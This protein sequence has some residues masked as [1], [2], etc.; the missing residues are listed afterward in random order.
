MAEFTPSKKTAQDF[1]NGVEYVDGIGDIEGDAVQA[2][3]INS[4]IEGLLYTQGLAVNQPDVSEANQVGTVNASIIMASD[5]TARL[6]FKN[7]KGEQGVGISTIVENGTDANGG[8]IYKI[9]LDDGRTYNLVAPKGAKG[10]TGN[11]IASTDISYASNASGTTAPTTGWQST[12]PTITQGGYLWTKTVV[13][14]TDNSSATSYT[15]AYQGLDGLGAVISVNGQTGAVVLTANDINPF[16]ACS[17][18]S[19]TAAKVVAK[20]GFTLFVGARITVSFTNANTV[21]SPTLNANGT[22]AK[23]I[24]ADDDTTYVK[25]LAGAV[26]DFVYDGINWVC[27]AGYQLAG[28]RVGALYSSHNSTSPAT[29]YGGSWTQISGRSIVAYDATEANPLYKGSYNPATQYYQNQ[30]VSHNTKYWACKQDAKG[31][32]PSTTNSAYWAEYVAGYEGGSADAVVVKHNHSLT[33]GV[34]ANGSNNTSSGDITRI[35]GSTSAN[36]RYPSGLIAEEGE[37]GTGKNM[38]PYRAEYMWYRTA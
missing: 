14:F 30:I 24:K 38:P 32:T 36:A 9:T 28:K 22:G 25:W 23:A 13:T 6:K 15:V 2:E 3:S 20:E 27:L 19:S 34:E 33:Y 21:N 12:I 1:N 26:M 17:T 35:M 29:L 37:D 18:N 16:V 7:L 31:V 10:D 4:V 8:N 5:G 11:G